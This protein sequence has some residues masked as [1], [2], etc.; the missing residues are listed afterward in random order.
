MPDD[1]VPY[2]E[3]APT[4]VLNR[5][6]STLD[7]LGQL[8]RV[9]LAKQQEELEK[10]RMENTEKRLLLEQRV[11]IL[12]EAGRERID[13]LERAVADLQRRSRTRPSTTRLSAGKRRKYRGR[14]G[15][16]SASPE[17]DRSSAGQSPRDYP[18]SEASGSGMTMPLGEA[19]VERASSRPVVLRPAPS[20]SVSAAP[21]NA[22]GDPAIVTLPDHPLGKTEWARGFVARPLFI[23]KELLM[24]VRSASSSTV[25]WVPTRKYHETRNQLLAEGHFIRVWRP[26][27]SHGGRA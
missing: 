8:H 19:P 17:Q 10:I 16:R 25:Y 3:P 4:E 14:S 7:D 1:P 11:Q 23:R 15:S 18:P 24:R 22:A 6:V 20:G 12:A 9:E 21:S 2:A 26:S 13:R 5:I 27:E